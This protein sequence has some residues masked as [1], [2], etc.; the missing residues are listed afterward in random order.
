MLLKSLVRTLAKLYQY[1]VFQRIVIRF[2]S[3]SHLITLTSIKILVLIIMVLIFNNS[4]EL[5]RAILTKPFFR[6]LSLPH[7]FTFNA[8]SQNIAN[9]SVRQIRTSSNNSAS[10]KTPD[11]IYVP[12]VL[13]WLKAKFRLKY[14]QKTWDPEFSEGAFIYGTTRA[15]CRITQIIHQD[16]PEELEGLLT[17]SAKNKLTYDM[18]NKITSL[19]KQIIQIR[20]EDIKI[21]VP[22]NVSLKTE[23]ARKTCEVSLR[24]LALKWLED[25]GHLK[26]VLVTLQTDFIRDYTTGAS[27]DW[28]IN[29]YD[30]LE[31]ALLS[32][33]TSTA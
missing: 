22:T 6:K 17:E 9:Y 33:S 25:G 15:V 7:Y 14:L 4:L 12:H 31:C 3:I 32:E 8:I 21:L 16:N 26:L 30:V 2:V 29:I 10:R 28:I 20:T 18:A 24:S 1:F 23:K 27:P 13:R 19:Q 11:L 5:F